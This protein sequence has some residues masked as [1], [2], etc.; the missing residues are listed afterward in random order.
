MAEQLF[1][2]YFSPLL[3]GLVLMAVGAILLFCPERLFS[4]FG[5][6]GVSSRIRSNRVGFGCFGIVVMLFTGF[7]V[8]FI[9]LGPSPWQ[10]AREVSTIMQV[11]PRDLVSAQILPAPTHYP[12]L[13]N[14]PANITGRKAM[15]ILCEALNS[16]EPWQPN[17]P[18]AVWACELRLNNQDERYR[19]AVE[20]TDNNGVLVY[21]Q[22]RG[23]LGGEWLVA[24]YRTD[25]LGSVL[26]SF[27]WTKAGADRVRQRSHE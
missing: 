8:V 15:K 25:K 9:V 27:V 1:S 17:H 7:I 5:M 24:T 14:A 11:Q 16:A 10:R 18:H 21:I 22:W 23:A 12:Q 20:S 4:M 13:V 2:T 26:E 19:C 3:I 6:K